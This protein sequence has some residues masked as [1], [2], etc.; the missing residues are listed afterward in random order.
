M[1]NKKPTFSRFIIRLAIAATAVSVAAMIVTLGMV[2]GFQHAISEKVFGF[3]GH[4]RVQ[5]IAPIRSMTA[6]EAPMFRTP[7]IDSL[8]KT[9]KN[10]V[11]YQTYAIKSV[12]LKTKENFEGAVLKGIDSSFNLSHQQQFLIEGAP[13][14]YPAT[15]YSNQVLVSQKIAATLQIKVSDTLHCFF[16]RNQENINVRPIVVSGIYKTG[17]DEYDNNFIIGDI[18]FLRRLNLWQTNEIGAYEAWLKAPSLMDS[19]AWHLYSELPQGIAAHSIHEIAPGIFDWLQVQDKTK[20]IVVII[21]I[22][23]AAINLITCLLILVME[24][25]QMIG[26]LKAMGLQT[27]NIKKIFWYYSG[28]ISLLGIGLG[29]IFG[30]GLC[31][32]QK[33][34][35]LIKMDETTYYLSEVPV[36]IIWW[37]VAGVIACSIIICFLALRLPLIYINKVSPVKAIRFN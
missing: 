36:Y 34:T 12:V 5:N 25:T 33:Y 4:V 7:Q 37:Q 16:I 2:N 32:L 27:A 14:S 9:D 28:Y 18:R 31:Y 21:M 17:I 13:I 22:I 26:V 24:R 19:T 30:L 15:G 35:G 3:W 11:H 10:I 23:V 1:F 8:L 29:L 20:S 6:E